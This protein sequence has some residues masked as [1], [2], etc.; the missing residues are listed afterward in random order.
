MVSAVT[1]VCVFISILVFIFFL[2]FTIKIGAWDFLVSS[3]HKGIVTVGHY[4]KFDKII[5]W[6]W[7]LVKY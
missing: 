7:D 2:Y 4:L 6:I 1:A 3:I 5:E